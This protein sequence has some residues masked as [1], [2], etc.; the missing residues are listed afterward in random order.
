MA[1]VL[2]AREKKQLELSQ[3]NVELLETNT[4]LKKFVDSGKKFIC[5]FCHFG[6]VCVCASVYVCVFVGVSGSARFTGMWILGMWW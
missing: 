3:E 6:C 4:I 5:V 1:T 2:E